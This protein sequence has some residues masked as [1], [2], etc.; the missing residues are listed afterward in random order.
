MIA[1]YQ[2]MLGWKAS[3]YYYESDELPNP[4]STQPKKNQVKSGS[5]A[6][7]S[8]SKIFSWVGIDFKEETDCKKL[9]PTELSANTLI[10]LII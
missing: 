7:F 6:T 9:N 1:I 5:W 10:V 8:H 3:Q 4:R 2:I